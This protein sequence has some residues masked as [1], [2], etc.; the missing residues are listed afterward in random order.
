MAQEGSLGT[1]T[2]M[3]MK[4]K[5]NIMPKQTGDMQKTRAETQPLYDL[6]DFNSQTTVKDGVINFMD[7]HR[8][9]YQA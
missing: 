5:M 2:K 7:W 1:E 6:V 8:A 9:F 3:K 4:M